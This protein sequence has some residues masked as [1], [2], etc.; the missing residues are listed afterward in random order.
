MQTL[1][2]FLTNTPLWVYAILAYLIW[3]GTQALRTRTMPIWRVLIVPL[4]FIGLGVSRML[5]THGQGVLPFAA[6]GVAAAVFAGL[7]FAAGARV[8]AVDRD[9]GPV[10]RPGGPLTL[11]R[12]VV[13]FVL[14]YAVAASAAM[15]VGGPVVGIA[16]NAV[17]GATAG[18]FIGFAASLLKRY[19]HTPPVVA[20]S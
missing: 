11:I 5:Q 12:N 10:T 20:A 14:Q 16:G 9:A 6:W 7:A 4:V 8:I 17:S 19:R 3:Q 18:F 2:G 13:V 1:I 15:H